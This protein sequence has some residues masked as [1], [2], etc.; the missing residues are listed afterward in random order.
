MADPPGIAA[1]NLDRIATDV[2]S[3]DAAFEAYFKPN[4]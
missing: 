4:R 1:T 3:I 2:T